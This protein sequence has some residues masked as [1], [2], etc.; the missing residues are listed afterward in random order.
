MKVEYIYKAFFFFMFQDYGVK[1]KLTNRIEKFSESF[2]KEL[3]RQYNVNQLGCDFLW[4]YFIFQFNFW[5]KAKLKKGIE[6]D[7]SFVVGKKAFDR[8]QK[9]DQ[10]YDW[11]LINDGNRK[12]DRKKFDLVLGFQENEK[13]EQQDEKEI[14]IDDVYRRKFYNTDKGFDYCITYTLLYNNKSKYCKE[15]KFVEECLEVQKHVYLTV[16]K[17]RDGEK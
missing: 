7:I 3:E 16:Y 14:D 5:K 6:I 12:Y 8:Y 15:C 17:D 11:Q 9:R 13:F 10:D 1:K 2:L 4:K